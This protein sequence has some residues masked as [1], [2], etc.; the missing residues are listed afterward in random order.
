[1]E[2]HGLEA[3]YLALPRQLEVHPTEGS[4]VVQRAAGTSGTQVETVDGLI[5]KYMNATRQPNQEP[6]DSFKKK[7]CAFPFLGKVA[8]D[9]YV[10]NVECR[11]YTQDHTT[12]S[13]T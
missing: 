9:V 13:N 2:F 12:S 11:A 1:M 4:P 5:N 7:G 3:A 8:C 6:M 10:H